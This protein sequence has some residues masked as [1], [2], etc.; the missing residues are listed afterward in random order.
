MKDWKVFWQN[1][2]L[3]TI[4]TKSDLLFQVGKTVGGEVITETQL[5]HDVNEII[6]HLSL[7]NEDVVLDLCCGNGVLSNALSFHVKHI[8]GVDFS[9]PFIKNAK[10]FNNRDN[11]VYCE[12]DI[13]DK[14]LISKVIEEYRVTKVLMYDCLAYFNPVLINELLEGLKD[15]RLNILMSSV[16]DRTK[17]W[18][19]YNTFKRKLA[20][21]MDLY[22]LGKSSGIGYW[23]DKQELIDIGNKNN[24]QAQYFY[25]HEANHTQHYRFNIKLSNT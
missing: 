9:A 13:L 10:E 1:Y 15:Y 16:L 5:E 14:D 22:I 2:R 19:F 20:Y 8:V 21:V 3:I 4:T 24:Y 12:A 17:K 6:E 23:W 7:T 25:H 11:I 18:V